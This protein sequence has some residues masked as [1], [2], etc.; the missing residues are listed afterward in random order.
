LEDDVMR[1]LV[2]QIPMPNNRFLVDLNAE[3][4]RHCELVHSSDVFWEM[5]GSFD[6][7][8]LHFPEYLTYEI[9]QAYGTGL[10]GDLIAATEKRLQ[11]WAGRS[12]LVVTRHVKLPHDALEDPMWAEMYE[13]FYRYADA[14]VHFAQPSI[15]EFRDRYRN[16]RFYRG[17]EP[18]HAIIPHHNY[19]SLP[20]EITP[21]AARARLK[22][23]KRAAVMLVFGAIRNEA[24]RQLVCDTFR[25]MGVPRKTLLV[26]KW[27]EK[28]AD[29][30]WIR[31]K[32]WLRDANR[33][34]RRI[35]PRYFFNYGFVEEKDAQVYLNAADVLFIPRLHVLNSGNI[36]LGMTFGRVVVGPDCLDV[37]ALLRETGN[38]VFAP[39]KP[40]SAVNAV[41]SGFRLAAE[42]KVGVENQ[43]VA[44]TQWGADQCAAQYIGVYKCSQ[45]K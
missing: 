1:V 6:V 4:S 19:C 43:K 20:N 38:P 2:A 37:G 10:T 44:L 14:V 39:D 31:L 40:E 41:E 13:T 7:V 34:Y 35:H 27:P 30:S 16:T 45:D 17:H 12:R 3:L 22:I 29:V 18:H 36:T 8:H 23:P 33:L 11:F 32:Y 5:Q 26:S 24:E 25:R 21:D 15:D 28:L 9:E 42:G